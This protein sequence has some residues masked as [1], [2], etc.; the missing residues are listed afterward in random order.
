MVDQTMKAALLPATLIIKNFVSGEKHCNYE[1]Y[2]LEFINKSPFFLEKSKGVSYVAPES[3]SK[4]E[5]DC[6][7]TDYCIDF[8][9]IASKTAL[10]GRSIYSSG[11]STL[12]DGGIIM[13]GA[14][15]VE[16][17]SIQ[18]TRI[19]AALRGYSVGDLLKLEASTSKKQGLENDI[20]E[21][22]GTLRTKKN[23]LL[24]FPY[25][26]SFATNYE[27][28]QGVEQIRQALQNDFHNALV[29]RKMHSDEHD[30]FFCFIYDGSVVFLEVRN[31]EFCVVDSLP[32]AESPLYIRLSDY[33]WT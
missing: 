6:N 10:Q 22:L 31:A 8:K 5:C 32:L 14:P 3:E 13:T 17:G 12:N 26:F 4:G 23:L 11:I 2:L 29:Y 21:L 15:K 20:W 19:H 18:T 9:L 27:F 33:S 24:Y 16:K 28:L 1:E 7:S 30:T 25:E